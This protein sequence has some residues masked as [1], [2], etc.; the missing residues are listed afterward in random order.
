[1]KSTSLL[2]ACLFVFTFAWLFAAG[3]TSAAGGGTSEA[4]K[5]FDKGVELYKNGN[6]V[7]ALVEFK[8]AYEAEPNWKVRYNV[9]MTLFKLGRF[10]EAE[11]E[12]KKCLDEGG[13]AMEDTKKTEIQATLYEMTEYIG[14]LQVDC[15]VSGA[16][17]SVNGDVVGSTPMLAPLRVNVGEYEVVV[18]A[19]G[20]G[21]WKTV[22]S[23][24]GG[25]NVVIEPVLVPLPSTSEGAGPAGSGTEAKAGPGTATD[26]TAASAAGT[27]VEKKSNKDVD[28]VRRTKTLSIATNTIAVV[29]MTA[30]A[31]TGWMADPNLDLDDE[32]TIG[33]SICGPAL[34]GLSLIPL[35]VGDSGYTKILKKLRGTG[36]EPAAVRIRVRM[37]SWILGLTSLAVDIVAVVLKAV[38]EDRVIIY[39]VGLF[40]GGTLVLGITTIALG[41]VASI[42][43]RSTLAGSHDTAAEGDGLGEEDGIAL[44]PYASP[45]QGGVMAGVAAAF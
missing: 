30:A 16:Q 11:A 39:G 42:R 41:A 23:V 35:A 34:Y 45:V 32:A 1:M 26:P 14:T 10:V 15:P 8:A 6:Y 3:P 44:V 22:A 5:R 7:A 2:P 38:P 18:T 9:G 21:T 33:P 4:K 36:I 25:K 17:V 29:F 19:E 27:M 28:L 13:D 31:G 12:L 40:Y 20:Y 37:A 24:P 43:I